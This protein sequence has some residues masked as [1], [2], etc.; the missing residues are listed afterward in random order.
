MSKPLLETLVIVERDNGIAMEIREVAHE[1][2]KAFL[3]FARSDGTHARI[4]ID[5][6]KLRAVPKRRIEV[7]F[8]YRGPAI[9]AP[10]QEIRE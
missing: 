7:D 4:E 10:E 2:G 5:P 1:G 9:K 6:S 3:I 8:Q